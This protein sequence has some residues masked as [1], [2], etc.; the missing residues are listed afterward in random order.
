MNEIE[1]IGP[2]LGGSSW[3]VSSGKV[4][5]AELLKLVRQGRPQTITRHGRPA[6]VVV[7]A[8]DWSTRTRRTS[9][10]VDF[11]IASPLRGA[12]DLVVTRTGEPPQ[13]STV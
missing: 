6:A 9:T 7:R 2:D 12:E 11:F 8:Q 13:D 5:F 1:L 10:L 3:T 4:H